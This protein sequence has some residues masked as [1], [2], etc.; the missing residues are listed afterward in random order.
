MATKGLDDFI[1]ILQRCQYPGFIFSLQ[2]RY[3]ECFL[4]VVCERGRDNTTGELMIW[5]GHKWWLSRHSTNSE[6]VQTAFKAVLTALEH[7]ARERFLYRG[8]AVLHGHYDL[9]QLATLLDNKV[10]LTDRR[11]EHDEKN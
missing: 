6:V 4:Q 2:Q 11:E 7:E 5:R 3:G 1:C 10:L 9:E 8:H